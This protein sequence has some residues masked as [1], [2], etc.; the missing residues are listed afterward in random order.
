MSAPWDTGVEYARQTTA[1]PKPW[2]LKKQFGFTYRGA[3]LF[4]FGYAEGRGYTFPPGFRAKAEWLFREQV[5][6]L[7]SVVLAIERMGLGEPDAVRVASGFGLVNV[8]TIS[9]ILGELDPPMRHGQI[10]PR[11]D[12]TQPRRTRQGPPPS[13]SCNV[14]CADEEPRLLCAKCLI[15]EE[16][17]GSDCSTRA[18]K[19]PIELIGLGRLCGR[20]GGRKA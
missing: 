16:A 4:A 7:D 8:V 20:C 11:P 17:Q 15:V 2:E 13:T 10:V 1:A 14:G 9:E 19:L 6:L 5:E 12:P 18:S 3:T